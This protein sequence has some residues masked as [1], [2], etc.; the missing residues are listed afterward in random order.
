MTTS[1]SHE[2]MTFRQ[3]SMKG[4]TNGSTSPEKKGQLFLVGG[5][6]LTGVDVSY[7]QKRAARDLSRLWMN[8]PIPPI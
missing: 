2:A 4:K 3:F 7:F 8:Y 5:F 6:A 1:G